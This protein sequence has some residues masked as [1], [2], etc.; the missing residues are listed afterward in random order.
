MSTVMNWSPAVAPAAGEVPPVNLIFPA[1]PSATTVN[2]D[3]LGLSVD[4]LSFDGDNPPYTIAGQGILLHGTVSGSSS[5]GLSHTIQIPVTLA[6]DL[7]TSVTSGSISFMAPISGPFGITT[8]S[9]LGAGAVTVL[10]ADNDYTGPTT[11]AAGI[12]RLSSPR[13]LGVGPASVVVQ[14][15]AYLEMPNYQQDPA[16]PK[17]IQVQPGAGLGLGRATLANL[18]IVAPGGITV[19][20]PCQF[21]TPNLTVGSLDGSGVL[22]GVGTMTVT[23][24][25]SFAGHITLSGSLVVNGLMPNGAVDMTLGG[26]ARFLPSLSGSGTLGFLA[27]NGPY[28]KIQ[29]TGILS[30]NGGVSFPQS[31]DDAGSITFH[32][33]GPNPGTGCD[34]LSVTGDVDFGLGPKLIY[35]RTYAYSIGDFVDIVTATGSITGTFYGLPDGSTTGPFTINYLP[36]SV[37]LTV[38]SPVPVELLEFSVE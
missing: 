32:L 7:L 27:V 15:G 29:P 17:I 21:C 10:G 36:H 1:G 22:P 16:T 34:Q 31:G 23:G 25:S 37:R 11:L 24:A 19:E 18:T 5:N 20:R 30:V 26:D 38:T 13:A 8:T 3:V 2:Q 33:D 35:K 6:A 12:L 14:A 28:C 9:A 4:S